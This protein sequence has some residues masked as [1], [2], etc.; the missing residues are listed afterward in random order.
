MATQILMLMLGLAVTAVAPA[1]QEPSPADQIV[2]DC[3]NAPYPQEDRLGEARMARL[4]VLRGLES[5]PDE[6]ADALDRAL[7]EVSDPR[8]RA[9]LAEALGQYVQTPEAATL[10]VKLLDDSDDHVRWEAIHGLRKLAARTDRSGGQRIQREPDPRPAQDRERLAREALRNRLPIPRRR[11]VEP[12]DERTEPRVEFAPKVEGLVPYLVEAAN[13]DVEANRICALYALADSRDPVAVAE[14]RDRLS[15]PSEKVRLYAA[16]LLTEYQ[17][18]SGLDE[19]LKA[20]D[21]LC[22]TDLDEN[23][24]L[25][26]TYYTDAERL[27]AS[28]ERLTG[29]S[30]GPIPMNPGLSSDMRQVPVLKER[31]KSLLATWAQWWAWQPPEVL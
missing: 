12:K 30:F 5:M 4:G 31:F 26:F 11:T 22:E 10:L 29:K 23:P 15:D 20:L 7:P 16:C 3:L 19:M 24:E 13:D 8:R 9:E 21:R 2:A 18:A 1:Q 14:L 17:D 27:L 6:A 25:E 28:F